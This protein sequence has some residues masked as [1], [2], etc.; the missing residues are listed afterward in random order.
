[1]VEGGPYESMIPP[2]QAIGTF[3]SSGACQFSRTVAAKGYD[4]FQTDRF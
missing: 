2:K 4:R 3:G 1:M